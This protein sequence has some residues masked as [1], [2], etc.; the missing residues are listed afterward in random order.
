MLGVKI[1]MGQR[2]KQSKEKSQYYRD[3][4]YELADKLLVGASN[5]V[6]NNNKFHG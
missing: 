6:T 2:K 1:L 4:S 3:E 5:D